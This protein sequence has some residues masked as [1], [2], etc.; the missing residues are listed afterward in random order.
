MNA[1]EDE[2]G[3]VCVDMICY[4]DDTIAHQLSTNNLRN[5]SEMKPPRL[6][7]SEV[8]RYMLPN[9]EEETINFMANNNTIMSSISNLSARISSVW[10]YFRGTTNNNNDVESFAYNASAPAGWYASYPVASFGKLVQA[11]MELPQVNPIYKM[12]SYQFVYGLG[13]S[14]IED[15]KIWDSIVKVVSIMGGGRQVQQISHIYIVGC[16]NEVGRCYMA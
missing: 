13:F 10:S 6:A 3:N 2:H 16:Q 1:F 9:I 5:P 4:A 7:A 15:G 11:S 12:H 14:S 8:R